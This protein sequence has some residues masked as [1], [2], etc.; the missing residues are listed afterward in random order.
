MPE[1]LHTLSEHLAEYLNQEMLD[2]DTLAGHDI[3]EALASLGL[4]L[5][6]DLTADSTFTYYESLPHPE[7][8]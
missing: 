3:L 2:H 7:D 8:E 1:S 4:T 5:V 6:E